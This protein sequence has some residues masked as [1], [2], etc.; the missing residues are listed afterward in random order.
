MTM[1]CV[2]SREIDVA[3]RVPVLGSLP[4][5]GHLFR[6]TRK[7]SV[8]TQLVIFMTI[9]ILE[10]EDEAIPAIPGEPP[11]HVQQV[12]ESMDDQPE[13]GIFR[14]SAELLLEE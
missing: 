11:E 8:R 2:E 13:A 5:V 12:L 9:H 3:R 7:Q 6:G 4:L 1:V 14:R 10:K